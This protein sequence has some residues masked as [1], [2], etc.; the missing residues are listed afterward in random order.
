VV[1]CRL[2]SWMS[3][4]CGG[5]SEPVS[6][7]L[8]QDRVLWAREKSP[9]ILRHGNWTRRGQT[10][11]YTFILPLSYHDWPMLFEIIL[12]YCWTAA[13]WTDF[14]AK[15][16]GS[17]PKQKSSQHAAASMAVRQ[18]PSMKCPLEKNGPRTPAVVR[19]AEGAKNPWATFSIWSLALRI[20]T[21]NVQTLVGEDRLQE[22]LHQLENFNWD[23]I[24]LSET[25]VREKNYSTLKPGE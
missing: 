23:I 11:R 5:A 9:V 4:G 17:Q 7:T 14:R 16:Y 20:C 25:R 6:A 24:S 3:T 10:V 22:L 8:A 2:F 13:L 21:H 19:W 1:R 18:Q 15:G 12:L